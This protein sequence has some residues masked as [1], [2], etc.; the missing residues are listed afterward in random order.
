M[1]HRQAGSLAT[2]RSDRRRSRGQV[3]VIFAGSIVLFCALCAIVVDVAWYWVA[4]LQVQ[5]AADAAALAGA[6]Y[7]PGDVTS[8]KA[9]SLASAKQNGYTAGS[10]TTV[11]PTQD[12]DDPRQMDVTISTSVDTYFARV[13]GITS[14][15]ITRSAKGVYVLPVPMGSPLAYYGVGTYIVNQTT[16]SVT[17]YSQSSSPGYT[18]SPSSGAWSSP[19]SAWSTSSAYAKSSSSGQQQ[20]WANL[21][22][23]AVSGTTITGIQVAFAAKVSSGSGCTVG[24]QLSWDGGSSWSSSLTAP[25]DTSLTTYTVGS[26]ASDWGA[27]AWAAS[28]FANGKL[29][30]RLTY[31]K[32]S[33]GTLSL[34]S[35]VVTV[36]SAGTTTS[37]S[38]TTTPGISD[39]A[40][41]LPS[42]GGWGAII[43]KGGNQENGDAYAP[44]NNVNYS[45]TNNALYDPAGYDY[46]IQ[47]PAG[48]NVKVFDPG[49]CAMGPNGSGGSLGAGDHWIGASGASHPVSTYYTLWNTNGRVGIPS[50]WT[51]VYGSGSLFENETGYDPSN[52]APGGGGSAPAGATDTCD[53]YHDAWWTIPTGSLSAGTYVLRVQTSKTAIASP[54]G[55]S[56]DSSINSSSNAENMFAI[57]VVGGGSPQVYGNGRMAVYNNLTGGVQQFYLAKIDQATGAGKTALIDLFDPGD[58]SGN[59]TLQVLNPDNGVQTVSTFSYTTDSNCVV[60]KSDAC[61]GTNRTSIQTAKS[62]SGSSFNSTWIHIQVPLSSTYGSGG[63]WQGGWWQIQVNTQG[64]NDTTTWQVSVR[65]NPVHLIAP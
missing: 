62:G 51:P 14:W 50:A 59:A 24:A 27:H 4:T 10:G 15:P 12:G 9:A 13:V 34:N 38:V 35:L 26:T 63:L 55:Q 32:A 52:M 40:T 6:V 21:N 41:F 56:A 16:T 23:P 61:S 8:G 31:N 54:V 58:V 53:A 48:G 65:G 49:F 7:L 30:L 57:E 11:T 47:L 18:S 2:P 39:G 37:T 1:T 45:P 42:G 60:G 25:L 3:A 29:V 28:D 20:S 43:T 33:C 17:T 22:V 5:R 36:T 46:T 64:G 19:N 44:A